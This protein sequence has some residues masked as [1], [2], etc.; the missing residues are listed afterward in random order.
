MKVKH[1][2]YSKSLSIQSNERIE[3]KRLT[4]KPANKIY[5]ANKLKN[6]HE[7][8]YPQPFSPVSCCP[9]GR[10]FYQIVMILTSVATFRYR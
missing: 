10:G 6:L 3:A 8:E 1:E 5:Q 9:F 7:V 2:S 4:I